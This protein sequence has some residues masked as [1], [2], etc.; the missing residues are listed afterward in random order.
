MKALRAALPAGPSMPFPLVHDG[1]MFLQTNP[2]L[3]LALDAATGD[4]LWRHA[5]APTGRPSSQKMGLAL[6][7]GRVFV[8][9]SD[10]HVIALDARIFI[11]RALAPSPARRRPPAA[12]AAERCPG[13]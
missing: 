3:V 2:D 1:V 9:T 5:Y 4:L 8:P 6:A 12:V 11:D 13:C 7:D 10:L